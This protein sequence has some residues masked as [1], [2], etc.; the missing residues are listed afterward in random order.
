MRGKDGKTDGIATRACGVDRGAVDGNRRLR[1]TRADG[2][3]A[4]AVGDP[5]AG[6][7]AR[8]WCG[9]QVPNASPGAYGDAQAGGGYAIP[10]VPPVNTGG[11][12]HGDAVGEHGA[13][14]ACR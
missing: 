4:D 9:P 7:A 10:P 11:R 5:R 1:R 12:G 6:R 13:V 3:D 2:A 14:S 8:R